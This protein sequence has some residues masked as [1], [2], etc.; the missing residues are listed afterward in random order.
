MTRLLLG[1]ALVVMAAMAG[2][3]PK[4]NFYIPSETAEKTPAPTPK[5][6][7]TP[8]PSPTPA[9]TPRATPKPSP[10]AKPS[11][12]PRPSP[13][14]PPAP[15]P[16]RPR[17]EFTPRLDGFGLAEA[18]QTRWDFTSFL[19]SGQEE[20]KFRVDSARA[21]TQ[22]IARAFT[23]LAN[24]A[25]VRLRNLNAAALAAYLLSRDQA[26]WQPIAGRSLTEAQMLAVTVTMRQDIH[27]MDRALSDYETLRG[28]LNES[29]DHEALLEKQ[30]LSA[31]PPN[32]LAG[33][34]RPT[35]PLNQV[36]RAQTEAVLEERTL[37]VEVL[38]AVLA[39]EK[40][41]TN[42]DSR[43]SIASFAPPPP[44][45]LGVDRP[46]GAVPGQRGRLPAGLTY[47]T[48]ENLGLSTA[49]AKT[50][51]EDLK[52]RHQAAAL[53][54]TAV[55]APVLASKDGIVVYAGPFRGYGTTVILEHDK[56]TFTVYSHLG[57]L[58]VRERQPVK[59]GGVIARAGTVPELGGPGIHFQ[60]RK[61]TAV[62]QAQEW[63]ATAHA[64]TNP[65]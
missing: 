6:A 14:P 5:P 37:S 48:S 3:D 4:L 9:P 24:E 43:Q 42:A 65:Q 53:I 52:R 35:L 61:G 1:S 11:P 30:G 20:L 41:S 45:L 38:K 54:K 34:D 22:R 40:L 26:T 39:S 7:S 2:A 12:T 16:V 23:A 27:A 46:A 33:E 49:T 8:K 58:Q 64:V 31:S 32:A 17:A 47:T 10:T 13:T 63:L 60:V 29:A 62:V 19:V 21:R 56:G 51:R 57:A 50:Q 15:K 28:A 36:A 18:F 44:G 25:E 59:R 55:N